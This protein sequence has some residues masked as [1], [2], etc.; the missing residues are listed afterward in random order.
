MADGRGNSVV[1]QARCVRARCMQSACLDQE[2]TDRREEVKSDP[3]EDECCN[4]YGMPHSGLIRP[5]ASVPTLDKQWNDPL[6]T[7]LPCYAFHML[8]M[9]SLWVS[10]YQR[11]P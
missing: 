1:S 4:A 8:P 7:P 3:P 5:V 9:S 11:I 2:M 10:P 6:G